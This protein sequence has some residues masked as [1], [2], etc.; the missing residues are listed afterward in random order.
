MVERGHGQGARVVVSEKK[1]RN[2]IGVAMCGDQNGELG[3]GAGEW[4]G[5]SRCVTEIENCP[6][7]TQHSFWAG[8]RRGIYS[9]SSTTN[10]PIR[11]T[12]FI[13]LVHLLFRAYAVARTDLANNDASVP[14]P[15]RPAEP[16]QGYEFRQPRRFDPNPSTQWRY[17]SI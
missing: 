10:F 17:G 15:G 4:E 7:R 8:V 12:S 9:G 16:P 5:R 14:W 11:S 3:G 2:R 1:N 13:S 6:A